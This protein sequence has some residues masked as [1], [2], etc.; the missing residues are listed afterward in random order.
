LE[1]RESKYRKNQRRK[2][3]LLQRKAKNKVIRG[4]K[5]QSSNY[6]KAAMKVAKHHQR[7]ANIRKDYSHKIT[8]YLAKNHRQVVIENLN[9]KGLVKNHTLAGAIHDGGFYEFKRQLEYKCNWYGSKLTIVDRFYPSSKTCSCCGHKKERLS[10][11]ERMFNC[12]NCGLSI[13]RDLNASLNLEKE[14]IRINN[15]E[16]L[17]IN[18]NNILNNM[19][20]S[21]TVQHAC[22]E[23][24]PV[25]IAST[26]SM[27]QEAN[28]KSRVSF[29]ERVGGS[30][31]DHKKRGI[32]INNTTCKS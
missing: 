28:T 9:L 13:D 30:R 11:D 24:K 18:S 32:V 31:S 1:I 7:I 20:V 8:S 26:I 6:T 12:E 25:D 16:N 23:V 27:K 14:G 5:R 19:A 10:L 3:K 22:G 17:K 29:A 21:S 15:E 2:L 4:A